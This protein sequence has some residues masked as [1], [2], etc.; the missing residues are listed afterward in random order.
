MMRPS[1]SL[2]HDFIS[3]THMEGLLHPPGPNRVNL[4]N[5]ISWQTYLDDPSIDIADVNKSLHWLSKAE[6]SQGNIDKKQRLLS[7]KNTI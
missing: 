4:P 1:A 7:R 3:I 6:L 5:F 2:F